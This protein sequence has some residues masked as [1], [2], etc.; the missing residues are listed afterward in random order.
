MDPEVRQLVIAQ[1]LMILVPV[2]LLFALWVS[3]LNKNVQR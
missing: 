2:G 1:L 3:M